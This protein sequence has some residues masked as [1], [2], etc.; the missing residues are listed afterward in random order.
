MNELVIAAQP[1]LPDAIV[2]SQ[3]NFILSHAQKAA[4]VLSILEPA[5]AAAM[6][7]DFDEPQILTFARAVSE[8]RPLPP[9]V[10]QDVV[11]E[12]LGH[13]SNVSDVRGGVD[14]VRSLLTGVLDDNEIDRIVNEIAGTTKRPIWER[15]GDAPA[16]LAAAYLQLQHPQTVSYV[17]AK[18]K[19]SKAAAILEE[20]EREVANTSVI[21]LA[22][23]PTLDDDVQDI[24]HST[25]ERDFL[26]TLS[27]RTN[28]VL[29]EEVIGNLMNNVSSEAREEFLKFL[30]ETNEDLAAAVVKVMFTFADIA[31]RVRPN[32]VTFFTKEVEE[33]ELLIA[34]KHAQALGNPTFDFI[35]SNLSKRLAERLN[36]ELDAMEEPVAKEAEAIQIK[37]V[38]VIQKKAK[39]GE[40]TLIETTD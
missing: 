22:R 6:M 26:S 20:I 33:E 30:S 14:Q 29:P 31:E 5:D 32:E 38:N 7:K 28:N 37:L 11:R 25:L 24:L 19:P 8:L 9:A 23:I 10:L 39:M 1:G 15:L 13:L 21:R 34:L 17:L 35:I 18:L 36:E 27:H 2:K 12:F 3:T 16:N 4:V 40:M